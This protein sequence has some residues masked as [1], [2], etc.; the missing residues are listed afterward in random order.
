MIIPNT[1]G[2]S[3][4]ISPEVLR[5][6][7]NAKCDIWSIGIISYMLLS[8]SPPFN[9]Q[10]DRS[11]VQAIREGKWEFPE[12]VRKSVSTAGMSFI[13]SC[14]HRQPNDRPTASAALQHKWFDSIHNKQT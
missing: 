6:N 9:G 8:G 3:Y 13:S 10:S 5:G 12:Y 1:V 11:V 7:Y 4:Y 2:T 14:L